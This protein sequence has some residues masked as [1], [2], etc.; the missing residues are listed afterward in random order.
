MTGSYTGIP[1]YT[2]VYCHIPYP[3]G[4][5]SAF[6]SSY[7][8]V[9]VC[10]IIETIYYRSTELFPVRYLFSFIERYIESFDIQDC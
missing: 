8:S 1:G 3:P 9:I 7:R 4:G 2:A 6:L 5:R 10:P